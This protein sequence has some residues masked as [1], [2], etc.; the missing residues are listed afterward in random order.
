MDVDDFWEQEKLETQVKFLENNQSFQIVYSNYYTLDQRKK[1]KFIQN[2]HELPSGLITNDLLKKYTIGILTTL[3]KK[4]YST[5]ILLIRI[6][7]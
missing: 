2:N 3:L 6:L 7:K 5:I 4:K 1:K